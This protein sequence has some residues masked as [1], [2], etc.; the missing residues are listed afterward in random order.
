MQS[1]LINLLPFK[2]AKEVGPLIKEGWTI[3]NDFRGE[4]LNPLES[5]TCTVNGKFTNVQFDER[6]DMD[7]FK[8]ISYPLIH[9][10]SNFGELYA[11]EYIPTGKEEFLSLHLETADELINYSIN[12]NQPPEI[13]KKK[14]NRG[15]KPKTKDE[16]TRKVGNGKYFNS[17]T[18]FVW[19]TEDVIP[20]KPD[21]TFVLI[22]GVKKLVDIYKIKVFR[23]GT[24]GI[25]GVVQLD[26]SDSNAPIAYMETYLSNIF[27][28]TVKLQDIKT[29]LRNCKT[30]LNDQSMELNFEEFGK[31]LLTEKYNRLDLKILDVEYITV[32]KSTQIKIKFSRPLEG[33]PTK[34]A[35]VKILRKKIDFEG[36]S[37]HHDIIEVYNWLNLF[38]IKNYNIISSSLE[39]IDSPMSSPPLSPIDQVVEQIV[40]KKKK[41]SFQFNTYN[42]DGSDED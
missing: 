24:T 7:L 40:E 28:K 35:T 20:K 19:A 23:N 5:S 25:P 10:G 11:P 39:G 21:K 41:K 36:F 1:I 8:N 12:K 32:Q 33:N 6:T 18:T 9:I 29:D 2:I 14:S 30:M 13:E 4:I 31:L 3:S 15:R 42:I 27:E 22:G 16:K 17:Q 38:M 26:L 34:Y 37:F